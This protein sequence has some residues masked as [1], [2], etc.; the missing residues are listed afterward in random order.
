M[1]KNH[2][3][4]LALATLLALGIYA[5]WVS[6][7]SLPP[8]PP[9]IEAI[10]GN[11]PN[12]V[13]QNHGTVGFGNASLVENITAWIG[14]EGRVTA[15]ST[16]VIAIFTGT[17]F[18]ATFGQLGQLKKSIDLASAEFNA[19]HRPKLVVRY[20]HMTTIDPRVE[21]AN[22]KIEVA[23]TIENIGQSGASVRQSYV[24][25]CFIHY[26]SMLP[27]PPEYYRFGKSPLDGKSFAAGQTQPFAISS[28][29]SIG[30]LTEK[31]FGWH[32]Y[33]VGWVEYVDT[34]GNARTLRFCREHHMGNSRF[35]KVDDPEY[36]PQDES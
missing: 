19:T 4:G 31:S 23:F 3:A 21:T 1:L 33:F 27:M 11:P 2:G 35:T 5:T 15:I 29:Y 17:L 36:E 22:R 6:F 12:Y 25:F 26:G 14:Q 13:A 24:G 20:I 8:S 34:L 28:E 16:V 10:M 30:D 7:S 9:K 32:Q 18:F